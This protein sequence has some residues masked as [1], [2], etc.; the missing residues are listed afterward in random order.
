MNLHYLHEARRGLSLRAQG[1]V[2]VHLGR[3]PAG[4]RP[5]GNK[6]LHH[7]LC[8]ACGVESYAE[9]TVHDATFSVGINLRCIEA[10]DVDKLSP[11][12]WDGLSK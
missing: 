8:A 3:R 5:V 2:H 10:I 4:R 12:P 1:E 9:G 11:R 7:R 6:H